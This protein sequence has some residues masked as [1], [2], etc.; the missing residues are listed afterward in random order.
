MKISNLFRMLFLAS[1]LT[2]SLWACQQANVETDNSPHPSSAKIT[3][4]CSVYSLVLNGIAGTPVPLGLQSFIHKIDPCSGAVTS[5]VQITNGGSSTNPIYSV[6]GIS[7]MLANPGYS[8]GV[9]G[10]NSNFPGRILK[11]QTATGNASIGAQTRLNSTTGA[12]VYLQDIENNG[13]DYFA[14]IEGTA[15]IV[16]VNISTGVCTLFASAPTNQLNGL[17]FVGTTMY[18]ISGTTTA[19]CPSN[20]GDIWRFNSLL[21]TAPVLGTNTYKN[22][23][24]NPTWTMKE[25]G[26]HFDACCNIKRFLVGSSSGILSNNPNISCAGVNPIFMVN[27]KP[28]YD[29][30]AE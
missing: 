23:P 2:I 14:I 19:I 24:A 8:W 18:V 25:L 17:T 16:R 30:M 21:L 6:T 22:L 3:A 20:S 1:M 26:F 29:F 13:T 12:I 28:T 5:V 10:V 4:G 11:I 7:N 9:T 27:I 15:R